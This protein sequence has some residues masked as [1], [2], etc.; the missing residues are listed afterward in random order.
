MAHIS[1]YSRWYIGITI[2]QVLYTLIGSLLVLNQQVSYKSFLPS[3]MILASHFP[4]QLQAEEVLTRA[5]YMCLCYLDLVG[6]NSSGLTNCSKYSLHILSYRNNSVHVNTFL[7]WAAQYI[8]RWVQNKCSGDDGGLKSRLN[9]TP[10]TPLGL[11]VID[12]IACLNIFFVLTNI[13]YDSLSCVLSN[14]AK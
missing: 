10:L 13:F 6:G 5:K 14:V 4:I 3:L 7:D 1:L 12:K 8:V 11:H 9:L 2:E